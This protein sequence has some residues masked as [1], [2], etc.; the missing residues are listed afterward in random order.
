MLRQMR[1]TWHGVIVCITPRNRPKNPVHPPV[2][3]QK[4]TPPNLIQTCFSGQSC[5][6]M[7]AVRMQ[8]LNPLSSGPA[9]PPCLRAP[10]SGSAT[11][12]LTKM[13]TISEIYFTPTTPT[14]KRR[15]KSPSV[16]FPKNLFF[17]FVHSVFA[18]FVFSR[19]S[20][21]STRDIQNQIYLILSMSSI[22]SNGIQFHGALAQLASTIPQTEKYFSSVFAFGVLTVPNV[23]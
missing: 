6:Q 19:S 8:P 22:F 15:T 16:R 9:D 14:E 3:P 13:N 18:D 5:R 4:F 17:V 20:A 2:G 10:A 1:K 12:K 11:P 7:H 23:I 21:I